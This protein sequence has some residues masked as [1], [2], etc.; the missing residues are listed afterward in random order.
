MIVQNGI[1][2]PRSLGLDTDVSHTALTLLFLPPQEQ[3]Y[4]F[5]FY[6]MSLAFAKLSII[7]LYMRIMVH[8]VQR[9]ANYVLLSI[10][11]ACNVWVFIFQFIQC[12]PLEALWNPS[13]PG[14]C[15]PLAANIG[16]SVMHIITD[17]FIFLLPIPTLLTL[18]IP[19][20]QK[21][22]LVLVFSFGFL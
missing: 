7:F 3:F 10:I 1:V 9:I 22:G 20:K 8:G 2:C 17:F 11:V 15:L 4:S 13:V 19:R 6:G 14:T 18:K 12:I 16:N 5:M 21:I